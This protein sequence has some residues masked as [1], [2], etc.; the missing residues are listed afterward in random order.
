MPQPKDVCRQDIVFLS[1]FEDL[2][3][4]RQAAKILYPLS[5]VLLLTLVAVLCGAESWVEIAKFGEKRRDFLR[6]FAPFEN[7]APS[8]DQL[9]D[10]FAALDAEAFQ[11]CFVKWTSELTGLGGEII[12]IDGKTLRRSYQR[13]GRKGAIHMISAFSAGQRL[14]VGQRKV[15]DKSNEITAIPQLLELL[16]LKGAIVTIDAMGCQRAIAAKIR[17]KQADYVLALK[18]NQSALRDDAELFFKEQEA[19]D[20]K[21]ITVDRFETVEKSH[22][23][24]E[25]RTCVVTSDIGWLKERHDWA[26]LTSIAALHSIREIDGRKECETRY[27]ISSLP[28][29]A[30]MLAGAIRS[31]WAVE[32]SLHWIMDMLFRDDECRIRKDNAPANFTVVKH[33]AANLL[34]A[35]PGKESMRV[36]RK[37]TNWD[38]DFLQGLITG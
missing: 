17:D 13:A 33:I 1:H 26:G 36:K 37:M 22:G 7:G 4:P 19:C 38:D 25:T 28:A 9:G 8:H 31:H 15:A 20:F 29:D 2:P 23:R 12:A 6:R 5:E 30:R 16:S 3:D 14:V 24:I 18:G 34:R 27:F 35:A 10:I 32:N 21:D 11:D